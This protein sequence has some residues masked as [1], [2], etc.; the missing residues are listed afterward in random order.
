MTIAFLLALIIGL[1]AATTQWIRAEGHAKMEATAR[2]AAEDAR[3]QTSR[4]L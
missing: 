2:R 1:V 4:Y 3:E